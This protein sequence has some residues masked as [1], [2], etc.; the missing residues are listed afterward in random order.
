MK[1]YVG[2]GCVLGSD[3]RRSTDGDGGD[4]IAGYACHLLCVCVCVCVIFASQVVLVVKNLP[5]NAGD[6]RLGFDPWIGK[7]P[8]RRCMATYSSILAWRILSTEEAWR[9]AV[10]G[11]AKSQI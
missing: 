9:T 10:Q 3:S 7:I 4:R 11:V 5:A 2:G 8:W 6:V 1:G